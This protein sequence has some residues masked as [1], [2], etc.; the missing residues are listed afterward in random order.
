[1]FANHFCQSKRLRNV[2]PSFNCSI[3]FR[4]LEDLLFTRMLIKTEMKRT[5]KE[6][7]AAAEGNKSK[8]A[9]LV[10]KT[11]QR[12]LDTCQLGLKLIANVTYGYTS[13]NYTG[14]MPCVEV[15]DSIV[16]KGRDMLE[17]SIEMVNT[18]GQESGTGARVIYGDTDSMFIS[19]PNSTR[20]EAFEHSKVL[21]NEINRRHRHPISIKL[22][23]VYQPCILFAKKRYCGYAYES[24]DQVTPAFDAKGIETVRRDTCDIAAKILEQSLRLLFENDGQVSSLK[25]FVQWHLGKILNGKISRLNDFIFAK[26]FSGFNAYQDGWTIPS[27]RVARRRLD[28]DPGDE[29][30]YNERIPYVIIEGDA[31]DNGNKG[32]GNK[33]QP[34]LADL[35]RDPLELLLDSKLCINSAY[36][37]ERV[38]Y[39]PL[40][41]V[42]LA[43]TGATAVGRRG[44]GG[45]GGV[46][47]LW[48]D[49]AKASAN[50]RPNK[51]ILGRRM[52]LMAWFKQTIC[53]LCH[54][55]TIPV[56]VA[57]CRQCS[58]SSFTTIVALSEQLAKVGHKMTNISDQCGKC[59]GGLSVAQLQSFN[60]AGGGGCGSG[61]V[62]ISI[63]CDNIYRYYQSIEN[64]AAIHRLYQQISPSLG[65]QH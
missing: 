62:C 63:D 9:K 29:A 51:L 44:G 59:S 56:G 17:R 14:R 41:R 55:N 19:F 34:R 4:L 64:F 26:E 1:M 25:S 18:W 16:A 40:E 12:K 58:D 60:Q 2:R 5:S 43:V 36:Y 47:H 42:L 6:M 61:H 46:L 54:T 10:L 52:K 22:E 31:G 33:N 20:Q 23:K 57:L 27:W 49:E 53:P 24:A 39:P 8:K 38:I 28:K 45:C 13:A 3:V 32:R 30:K 48:L 11:L 15:A 7:A 50:K 37:I 65:N 21:V 35:A